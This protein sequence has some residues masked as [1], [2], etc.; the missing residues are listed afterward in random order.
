MGTLM[1]I[2]E[3]DETQKY[4][5]WL[6]TLTDEQRLGNFLLLSQQFCLECGRIEENGRRCQCWN[7]E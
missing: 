5:D 3:R 6:K 1:L 2:S 7:D 4:V